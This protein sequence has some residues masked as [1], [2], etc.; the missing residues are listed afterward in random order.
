MAKAPD[1]FT[2]ALKTMPRI[3]SLQIA[4]VAAG[5]PEMFDDP[6]GKNGDKGKKK[7]KKGPKLP[8]YK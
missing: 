1:P 2:S 6:M 4:R 5:G 7:G 3:T 8:G